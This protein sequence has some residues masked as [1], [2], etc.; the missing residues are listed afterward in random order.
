MHSFPH[1]RMSTRV[2]LHCVCRAG[3][4]LRLQLGT[5]PSGLGNNTTQNVGLLF[6]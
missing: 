6:A 4:A 5:S 3:R 1:H 2:L